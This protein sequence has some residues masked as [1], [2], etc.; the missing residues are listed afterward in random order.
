M[1]GDSQVVPRCRS[2]PSKM[3]SSMLTSRASRGM[4]PA[5]ASKKKEPPASE[6]LAGDSILK[7]N[8]P[9]VRQLG[10]FFGTEGTKGNGLGDA[11]GDAGL[12]TGLSGSVSHRFIA[13]MSS[14]R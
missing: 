5:F 6:H 14:S 1:A 13:I 12:G 11:T 4:T 8:S 9:S 2:G 10:S 3:H 7:V